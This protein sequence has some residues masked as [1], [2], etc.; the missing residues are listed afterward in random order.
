MCKC[1]PRT[2]SAPV[3]QSESQ[4]LKQFLL[5][6][7]GGRPIFRRSSGATTKKGRTTF[8]GKKVQP[9]DKILAT[10]MW[11]WELL[12]GNGKRRESK[13]RIFEGG[14]PFL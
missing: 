8:F 10:P 4:F 13:T 14:P 6:R 9:P 5:G 1:T 2:R 3:S 11:E 12:H 7:F